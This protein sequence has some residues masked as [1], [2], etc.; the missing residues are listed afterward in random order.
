MWSENERVQSSTW[1]EL[2]VEFSLQ[3]FASVLEGSH[4]KWF[5]DNQAAA[6]IVEVGNMKLGLHKMARRIFPWDACGTP[7]VKIP[8][9]CTQNCKA[10]Q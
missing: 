3:S 10:S 1:K 4:V 5:T 2:S 9:G 8:F 7:T 6:K